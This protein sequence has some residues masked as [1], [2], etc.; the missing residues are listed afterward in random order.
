MRMIKFTS[1]LQPQVPFHFNSDKV[2]AVR[3]NR[4][5]GTVIFCDDGHEYT[6]KEKVTEV[7]NLM[8]SR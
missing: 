6:V 1:M 8:G 3:E 7:L 2:V 4:T 5:G